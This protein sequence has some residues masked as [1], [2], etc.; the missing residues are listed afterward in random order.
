MRSTCLSAVAALGMLAG[1]AA[2]AVADPVKI[3]FW[4]GNSGDISKGVQEVCQHFN[5]SQK[6]YEVDCTSQGTYYAAV[7]NTIAAYRASKQ[8]TIVQVFDVG[9]LMMLSDAYSPA[10]KLMADNGYTVDWAI[11]SPASPPI[12]PTS[13]GK[14]YSI[15]FNSSTALLY[16]NQDAFAKIGKNAAPKTWEEAEA[17]MKALKA[18]GYDCPMAIDIS[19]NESW[20]LMEQFSA[21]HNQPIATK[22][23]GYDGLDAELVFNKTCSCVMSPIS[24]A[25]TTP[26]WSRS[27]RRNPARTMSRPSPPA[28]A[29]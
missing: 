3:D 11:T 25:G 27:S 20:Q 23:N 17:D 6:D 10:Y 19:A 28:N 9:T 12:T 14:M 16:W 1:L 18:A 29:R 15:P 2:P 22:N 7:Q 4:Y 13:K 24:S 8:P 26:G 5:Q 21:I